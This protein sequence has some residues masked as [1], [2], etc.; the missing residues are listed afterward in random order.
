MTNDYNCL[1]TYYLVHLQLIDGNDIRDINI[2]HLRKFIGLVKQEPCLFDCSIREN[3]AYGY[4]ENEA[5]NEPVPVPDDLIIN[6]A[7][8][9]NIHDFIIRL[10]KVHIRNN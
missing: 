3:I 9:A 10:P 6:A 8:Q 5:N 4:W 1:I 2:S 7:K